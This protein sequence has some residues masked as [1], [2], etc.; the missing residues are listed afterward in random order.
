V[1][2]YKQCKFD[3]IDEDDTNKPKEKVTRTDKV[4]AIELRT[5]DS[6]DGGAAMLRPPKPSPA[7]SDFIPYEN[8]E[9]EAEENDYEL[10]VLKSYFKDGYEFLVYVFDLGHRL[11]SVFSFCTHYKVISQAF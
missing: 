8:D 11:A 2:S 6:T 10:P 7:A 1:Y 4:D 3:V 9:E 5:M